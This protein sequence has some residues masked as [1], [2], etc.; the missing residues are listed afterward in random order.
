MLLVGTLSCLVFD[1]SLLKLAKVWKLCRCQK[2]FYVLQIIVGFWPLMMGR[3]R[4]QSQFS[5]AAPNTFKQNHRKDMKTISE[6]W[7]C[8]PACNFGK[9]FFFISINVLLKPQ[10]STLENSKVEVGGNGRECLKHKHPQ[11]KKAMVCIKI[12][13][14]LLCVM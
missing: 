2:L 7:L 14:N 1:Q 13:L 3:E 10:T 11:N 12:T 4:C 5:L 6:L 8:S 9:C